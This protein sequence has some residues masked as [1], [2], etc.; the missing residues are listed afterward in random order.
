ME[1]KRGDYFGELALMNDQVRA[2][3]IIAKTDCK[4]VYVNKGS[5]ERLLGR[6]EDILKRNIDLYKKFS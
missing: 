5:F 4:I 2:A 1:Y 3:T 6:V